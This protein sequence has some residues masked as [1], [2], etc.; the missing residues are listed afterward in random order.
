MNA[1]M[2][3]GQLAAAANVAAGTIRYYERIGLL[4][5]ASR[6]PAGYRQYPASIVHRLGV[7]RNAQQF[8][9]SLRDIA[10]FLSVRDGGGTPCQNVRR[11]AE[12]M[13]AAVDGQIAGLR[14]KRRQM[15]RTLKLW[16]DRLRATPADT[17]AYLLEM[18]DH[19]KRP[20]PT[21]RRSVSV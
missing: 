10:S 2:T 17:R 8:G 12:R 14:A 18:I 15:A 7:I 11:T 19:G 5:R 21:R 4:P 1:T 6:T 9:F 20:T 13:L 3:I 16:D